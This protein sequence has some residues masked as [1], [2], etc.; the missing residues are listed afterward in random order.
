MYKDLAAAN[1][2]EVY[3]SSVYLMIVSRYVGLT[4]A[5]KRDLYESTPEGGEYSRP[6]S[7][8]KN[9]EF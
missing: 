4:S 7:Y 9:S 2:S 5:G 6:L 8:G 3:L 1:T